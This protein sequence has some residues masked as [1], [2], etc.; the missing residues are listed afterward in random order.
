MALACIH[1]HVGAYSIEYMC[2]HTVQLQSFLS[3]VIYN[4]FVHNKSIALQ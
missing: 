4:T 3:C 1:V 2:I